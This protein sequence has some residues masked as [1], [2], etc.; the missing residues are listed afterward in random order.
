MRLIALRLL[1]KE[2]KKAKIA[3]GHAELRQNNEAERNNLKQKID[4]LD[5]IISVVWCARERGD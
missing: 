5:W 3:L 2:L 4:T 1:Y